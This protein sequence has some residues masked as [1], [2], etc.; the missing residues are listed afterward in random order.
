MHERRIG[1]EPDLVARLELV[2]FA[3]HRDDFLAAELGED[4]RLRAGRLD[5]H[6]FGF[7]AVVGD[8]EVLGPDAVDRGPAVGIGGRRRQ[9]KFHAVRAVE[10]DLAVR[11]DIALFDDV[12]CRRADELR[13]EEIVRPVVQLER[14]AD[15]LDPAIVH[16]HDAVGHGHRLDLVVRHVDRRRLE[17]L[18]QRLDLGAHRDTQLGIQIRQ[19]LVEQEHLGVAHDRPPHRDALPLAAGQLARETRQIRLEV[20]DL[21]RA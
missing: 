4:L 1:F 7:G 6:D 5:H 12:H 20:E 18:M 13:D 8:G 15:L 16:H 9:R 11:P 3:E 2:T 21:R 19:R 14:L 10:A 17:P